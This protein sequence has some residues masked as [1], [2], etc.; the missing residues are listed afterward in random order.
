M[1]GKT[2]TS[3]FLPLTEIVNFATFLSYPISRSLIMV[4]MFG[5]ALSLVL[6]SQNL[7]SFETRA[8]RVPIVLEKLEKLTGTKL[9]SDAAMENEVVVVRAV[10]V[11]PKA[12]YDH[13]AQAVVGKWE[14]QNGRFVLVADGERRK[15]QEAERLALREKRIQE[16]L[17]RLEK[18]LRPLSSEEIR[19]AINQRSDPE[20]IR[21][22]P[23]D[24]VRRNPF[25]R[26]A[27]RAL[28]AL[29]AK[30]LATVERGARL[31]LST[32]PTRLETAWPGAD[33]LLSAFKTETQAF[34]DADTGQA[35]E[36][37]WFRLGNLFM[38][39]R[40]SSS[41]MRGIPEIGS[42]YIA[43]NDLLSSSH[44]RVGIVSPDGKLL[45]GSYLFPNYIPALSP[46]AY[47]STVTE[48][49]LEL[50]SETKGLIPY[51]GSVWQPGHT[52]LPFDSPIRTALQDPIRNEP[53]R[54]GSEM[55]G[56]YAALKKTN[57]VAS[58]NDN[59]WGRFLLEGRQTTRT[60]EAATRPYMTFTEDEGWLV[61]APN[62]P[63]E[64]RRNRESRKVMKTFLDSILSDGRADL[65]EMA[66]YA[67]KRPV[68]SWQGLAFR[69]GA[70]LDSEVH[71]NLGHN[72]D[73]LRIYGSMTSEQRRVGGALVSKLGRDG[74]A[75]V[76]VA[77]FGRPGGLM[78]EQRDLPADLLRQHPEMRYVGS[79]QEPT[80]VLRDGL[81]ADAFVK[82]S[83]SGEPGLRL[84]DQMFS[85]GAG[86]LESVAKR[87]FF[88]ANPSLVQGSLGSF[89]KSKEY[90]PMTTEK[91]E[92]RMD[93]G[94][95]YLWSATLQSVRPDGPAVPFE[96]LPENIT[97]RI[98][99][100]VTEYNRQRDAGNP[101]RFGSGVEG[102][103]IIP[104][105]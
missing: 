79:S 89:G 63:A 49:P 13:L 68:G 29:G 38:E 32:N 81:P 1:S 82:V 101:Q 90:Y 71:T 44:V 37:M 8:A 43:V 72:E 83:R 27:M 28:V 70:L 23:A 25:A 51:I 67:A 18:E 45:L 76:W 35:E 97:S 99:E 61:L 17:D 96:K 64:A 39:N 88:E 41:T 20:V 5:I 46:K 59:A 19:Q 16:I 36:P 100:L 57:L 42:A 86:V 30:K 52:V 4:W 84:T 53:L 15:V 103:R 2:S 62:Q 94:E 10:S 12:L 7:I 95:L 48:H 105:N 85:A 78:R 6:G 14:N 9:G 47:V 73:A 65:E 22:P 11:T 3:C 55:Y 56:Q 60:F 80:Q 24:L 21:K 50:D 33:R 93:L 98:R 92:L 69:L 74:Q 34:L 77:V 40:Q 102:Q 58:L 31:V 104:P 87:V 54:P 66:S 75:A 26:L 91:I